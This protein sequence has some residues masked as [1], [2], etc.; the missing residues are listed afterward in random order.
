MTKSQPGSK[1]KGNSF[2]TTVAPV[3][4]T[5]KI[6]DAVTTTHPH[7]LKG[8]LTCVCCAQSHSLDDCQQFKQKKHRNKISLLKEKE[9]CFGCLRAGH[10]SH[11]CFKRLK[12]RSCG[13]NHPSLLHI[14][15]RNKPNTDTEP[16]KEPETGNISAPRE[17]CG[18]TGAGRDRCFLSILPVQVKS[19]KGDRIIQ[20]YAFLDPGSH[21]TFCSE[22]LMRRLSLVGRRTQFL[23]QTMGWERIVPSYECAELEVSGLETDIFYKLP[24][25]LTQKR[26]P[27]SAD[28]IVTD[29]DIEKWPYLSKVRLVYRLRW[30]CLLEAMHQRCWSHGRS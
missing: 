11:D 29:E 7:S 3:S 9:L 20:T 19:I 16:F 18:H 8:K 10:M 28:N 15:K 26:M 23:L 24:E 13:G 30:I 27:V 17:T 22:H 4:L 5:E 25:V 2:A 1:F 21:A 6:E 12:C 14:D